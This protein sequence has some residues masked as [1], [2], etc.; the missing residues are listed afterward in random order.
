MTT[1]ERRAL[2]AKLAQ[3]QRTKQGLPP[4]VE[5]DRW[6]R[7]LADLLSRQEGHQSGLE[8]SAKHA[9]RQTA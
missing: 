3:E 9:D 6:L 5:N 2:S 4:T 7:N 8:A 1:Q